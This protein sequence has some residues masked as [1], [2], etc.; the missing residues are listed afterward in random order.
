VV[1]E[2]SVAAG[3]DAADDRR[4]RDLLGR[5]GGLVVAAAAAAA[6]ARAL[7]RVGSWLGGFGSRRGRDCGGE[8]GVF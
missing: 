6:C 1:Q 8:K 7:G 5:H 3:G 2:L 4:G